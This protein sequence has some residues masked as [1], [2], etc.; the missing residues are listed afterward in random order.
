M[1]TPLNKTLDAAADPIERATGLDAVAL[2]AYATSWIVRRRCR[3]ATG[4]AP[5]HLGDVDLW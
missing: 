3:R 1:I 5:L 2:T 4:I